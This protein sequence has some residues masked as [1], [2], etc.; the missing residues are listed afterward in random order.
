MRMA[1]IGAVLLVATLPAKAGF[2]DGNELKR[3]CDSGNIACTTYIQGAADGLQSTS[4]TQCPP[5]GTAT[6]QVVDA[7]KKYLQD[8]PQ[9]RTFSGATLV[10]L[11][12][13][14]AWQCPVFPQASP[15]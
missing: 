10:G 2:I 11:A 6:S 12:I 4:P 9:Y 8:F 1:T 14:A 5:V 7:V 15:K 3:D 13:Q